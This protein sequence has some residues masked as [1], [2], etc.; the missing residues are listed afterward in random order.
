VTEKDTPKKDDLELD[1]KDAEAVKGG[2]H[3]QSHAASHAEVHAEK[4]AERVKSN[5]FKS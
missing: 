2:A 1:E 4:H 5:R 3:R